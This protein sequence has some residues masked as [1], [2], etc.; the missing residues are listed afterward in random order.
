M[1]KYLMIISILVLSIA[2]IGCQ[3]E[4]VVDEV[5][6]DETSQMVEYGVAGLIEE[7][8]TNEGDSNNQVIYVVG[9]ENNGATY[10]QAYV[11]ITET[12][13]IYKSEGLAL[14]EGAYV[15]VFFEG[16]VLESYPVQA[17]AKQINIIEPSFTVDPSEDE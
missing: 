13:K 14:E 11:T 3:S 4:E 16:A 9:D 7:I 10:Q 1:K 2:L 6:S 8:E 17:T 12:T 5:P 15:R